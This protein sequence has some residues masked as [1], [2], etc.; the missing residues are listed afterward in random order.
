MKTFS[1]YGKNYYGHFDHTRTA[2]RAIVLRGGKLL[3]SYDTEK[4]R[5]MS[6]GG[7]MEE[8]EDPAACCLREA[9]EETG[10]VLDISGP[11][12][13]IDEYRP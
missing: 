3:M 8:G 4:S 12:L 9:A 11:V 5:W 1:I 10:A 2:C 7:G 13:E 6:P